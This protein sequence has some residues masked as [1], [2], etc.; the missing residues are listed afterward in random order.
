MWSS[1][2]DDTHLWNWLHSTIFRICAECSRY[3]LCSEDVIILGDLASLTQ[4]EILSL[5]KPRIG[6]EENN[7]VIRNR[8]H[9]LGLDLTEFQSWTKKGLFWIESRVSSNQSIIQN[10]QVFPAIQASFTVSPFCVI[11][12]IWST[13]ASKVPEC[14]L[15]VVFTTY[16]RDDLESCCTSSRFRWIFIK[17]HSPSRLVFVIIATLK[18]CSHNLHCHS[19]SLTMRFGFTFSVVLTHLRHTYEL[20]PQSAKT[21]Y[22][23][24]VESDNMFSAQLPYQ[25]PIS[26]KPEVS[27]TPRVLLDAVSR[28]CASISVHSVGN[29]S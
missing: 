22:I 4:V 14:A 18:P 3:S 15:T 11:W 24:L 16:T 13:R 26:H 9:C 1:Q 20:E 6:T 7:A 8:E 23:A 5:N 29:N 27:R 12:E 21:M 2:R 10:F 25:S 28:L 17:L 19:A